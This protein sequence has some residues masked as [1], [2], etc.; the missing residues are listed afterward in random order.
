MV[1]YGLIWMYTDKD[2]VFF[3]YGDRKQQRKTS[4]ADSEI[5]SVLRQ[6]EITDNSEIMV[7]CQVQQSDGDV[8]TVYLPSE[9][10]IPFYN[11][12][13]CQ[14]I[15][16]DDYKEDLE[17]SSRD[18]RRYKDVEEAPFSSIEER[19]DR[20]IVEESP[21]ASIDESSTL[22]EWAKKRDDFFNEMRTLSSRSFLLHKNDYPFVVNAFA[23]QGLRQSPSDCVLYYSRRI[24][25]FHLKKNDIVGSE[26]GVDQYI[27]GIVASSDRFSYLQGIVQPEFAKS[28][29]IVKTSEI[30]FKGC[31][32]LGYND[33][34]ADTD[35]AERWIGWNDYTGL[36]SFDYA[37]TRLLKQKHRDFDPRCAFVMFSAIL[38]RSGKWK[39]KD[40]S[41]SRQEI[42]ENE[43]QMP[44]DICFV[45]GLH[46][47]DATSTE[48]KLISKMMRTAG[49]KEFV[50]SCKR[51]HFY[52]SVTD[53]KELYGAVMIPRYVEDGKKVHF[54]SIAVLPHHKWADPSS[55]FNRLAAI[56]PTWEEHELP[57]VLETSYFI[58]VPMEKGYL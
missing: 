28:V 13:S 39:V 8:L 34:P 45:D 33:N 43:S 30:I 26:G 17:E 9:M 53:E 52:S 36:L 31:A 54:E 51:E 42:V 11:E 50:V 5:C 49:G 48:V 41:Y 1:W 21:M 25:L 2:E 46:I 47:A 38:N 56:L 20:E 27:R 4:K 18:S 29:K 37:C 22:N 10:V 15:G 40:V 35:K 19:R 57:A 3:K 23:A 7:P 16:S 32:L 58:N 44:L 24:G 12:T 55:Q 6:W 14:E